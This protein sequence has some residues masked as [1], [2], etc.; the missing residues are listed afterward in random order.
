MEAM[1]VTLV[2]ELHEDRLGEMVPCLALNC[3]SSNTSL[4]LLY[5][6]RWRGRSEWGVDVLLPAKGAAEAASEKW[7]LHL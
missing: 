1:S 3:T 4:W 7:T 2:G 6:P 5:K